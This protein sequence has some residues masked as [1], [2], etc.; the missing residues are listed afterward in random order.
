[1]KICYIKN[2]TRTTNDYFF[3]K[4]IKT[5]GRNNRNILEIK[6]IICLWVIQI[7]VCLH[8]LISKYFFKV[9]FE[10]IFDRYM[11]SFS[12]STFDINGYFVYLFI[13]YLKKIVFFNVLLML[14]HSR[15]F[16]VLF[17]GYQ[18]VLLFYVQCVFILK[19]GL[20]GNI[21]FLISVFPHE[22]IYI[23]ILLVMLRRKKDVESEIT[24]LYMAKEMFFILLSC[25]LLG[26][27]G[28]YINIF[29]VKK[30]LI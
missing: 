19:F 14:K 24:L 6:K 4:K 18:F 21:M 26:L 30:L 25:C 11:F 7:L 1:M 10:K 3:R 23:F 29:V 22:L 20:Y 16:G 5:I 9:D 17:I 2:K 12:I 27:M 8:I 13:E 28:S 15:L